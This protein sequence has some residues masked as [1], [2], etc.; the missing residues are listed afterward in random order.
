MR[1]S[2]ISFAVSVFLLVAIAFALAPSYSI[3]SSP[4]QQ[5]YSDL[6]YVLS[7]GN[8]WVKLDG[9]SGQLNISRSS[10]VS[11]FSK[12]TWNIW[13]KQDTYKS[14]AGL[15]GQYSP[16]SG[17]RA[18]LIRTVNTNG[19]SLLI[20]T[21]GAGTSTYSSDT[22]RSCGIRSNGQWTMITITYDG[23][24]IKYYRNGLLCDT[25]TTS[26]RSIYDASSPLSIGGGNNVFFNGSVD[27]AKI[28]DRDLAASQVARLYQESEHGQ[29]LGQ[30]IPVILYHQIKSPATSADIITPAQFKQHMDYLKQ[31]GFT[32]I[33]PNDYLN[34]RK[35][36]FTMPSKPVIIYF[37]DGWRS[38][39]DNAYPIMQQYGFKGTEA[40][41]S[42]YAN[43]VQGGPSYMHW[44]ELKQLQDSGWEMTSH[45][46][47]HTDMLTF[48]ESDFRKQ[49]IASKQNITQH[50]GKTPTSFVFPF[51]RSNS[52]YTKICGDYY[53]LCWTYGSN[54]ETPKYTFKSDNPIA[55][56]GLKRISISNYTDMTIFRNIFGRDTDIQGEWVIDE[57]TGSTTKDS[58]G[59]GNTARLTAGSGWNTGSII[60]TPPPVNT[61]NTTNTNN[62]STNSSS[63]DT[64]RDGIINSND[65][66]P[67]TRLPE[68]FSL[69]IDRFGNMDTDLPFETKNSAGNIIENSTY[70]MTRTKGCSCVQILDA[71]QS[72]S[73]YAYAHGCP[74]S[75][76]NIWIGR[77]S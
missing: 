55:Y 6:K 16:S 39:Y 75:T 57:G 13:V 30:A 33:T 28:Y 68:N 10:S 54:P 36:Q 64:D 71:L 32:S 73:T 53:T 17:K 9:R 60:T 50:L 49:L 66:C 44:P 12:A 45:G 34:W 70:T 22:T 41:V 35:G 61:T 52:T 47:S 18:Y 11:G 59:N 69:V 14:N 37:D 23:S 67:N 43:G 3:S 1:F 26:I 24:S 21:D 7:S 56:Q 2:L 15:F 77:N 5:I 48:S 46:M 63:T 8:I 27:D 40:V 42:N 31:Q 58:S 62:T 72:T 29:K 65:I 51:H 4:A 76:L 25:D 20:S 38:V 74:A 19:V